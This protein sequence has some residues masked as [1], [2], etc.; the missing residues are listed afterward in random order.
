MI[1]LDWVFNFFFPWA[2]QSLGWLQAESEQFFALCI[3]RCSF[4]LWPTCIVVLLLLAVACYAAAALWTIIWRCRCGYGLSA[5]T[6]ACYCHQCQSSQAI[7][8][9]ILPGIVSSLL[10][11]AVNSLDFLQGLN[12]CVLIPGEFLLRA[13]VSGPIVELVGLSKRLFVVRRS[14]KAAWPYAAQAD[15]T[16]GW[17]F[18]YKTSQINVALSLMAALSMLLT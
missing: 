9:A 12:T 18:C 3:L 1:I 16:G 15:G 11:V 5:G 2:H 8:V 7:R 14:G 6:C 13:L 17:W 4:Q 10:Q